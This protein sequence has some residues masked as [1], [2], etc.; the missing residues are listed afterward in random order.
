MGPDG[1]CWL[2]THDKR[3]AAF[4]EDRS[5]TSGGVLYW[6]TPYRVHVQ[7]G[8][9]FSLSRAQGTWCMLKVLVN[10]APKECESSWTTGIVPQVALRM[11]E[12]Q[13]RFLGGR[14]LSF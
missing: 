7:E 2:M 9:R 12:L 14:V 3:R 13:H 1:V 4:R 6:G 11:G 5:E 10:S 8:L